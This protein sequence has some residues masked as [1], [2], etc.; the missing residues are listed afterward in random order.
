MDVFISPAREHLEE[1]APVYYPFG[2]EVSRD[3]LNDFNGPQKK[4]KVKYYYI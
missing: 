3:A 4:I 2:G 1:I